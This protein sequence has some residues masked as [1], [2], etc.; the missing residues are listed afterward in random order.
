MSHQPVSISYQ[1]S[2]IRN[3]Q[4]PR[5]QERQDRNGLMGGRNGTSECPINRFSRSSV[6]SSKHRTLG[7][8][9]VMAVQWFFRIRVMSY[10]PSAICS[11]H[12]PFGYPLGVPHLPR[13]IT[14][15][16]IPDRRVPG[17]AGWRAG[18]PAARAP[19]VA[20]R[21]RGTSLIESAPGPGRS[22]GSR[23]LEAPSP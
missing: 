20:F 15:P 18:L 1:L 14:S 23:S 6:E 19:R 5:R 8:L 9:G 3:S 17:R 13:A 10:E 21:S 4:P 2:P 7:D 16:R 22:R 12:S 11:P